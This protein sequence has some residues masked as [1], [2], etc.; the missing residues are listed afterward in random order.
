MSN[1]LKNHILVFMAI[2]L[3]IN[4]ILTDREEKSEKEWKEKANAIIDEWTKKKHPH[5]GR[6]P[7]GP[8]KEMTD[9]EILEWHHAKEGNTGIKMQEKVPEE[10]IGYHSGNHYRVGS[11][12][13]EIQT[14]LLD[15]RAKL[16]Y[17]GK[18]VSVIFVDPVTWTTLDE[19]KNSER[20]K[21]DGHKPD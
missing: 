8:G 1:S 2:A 12:P 4:K 18:E 13:Q 14:A 11:I 17:G 19:A 15:G 16:Q 6:Y 10:M 3:V 21:E 7:W 9:E 5:S 20:R